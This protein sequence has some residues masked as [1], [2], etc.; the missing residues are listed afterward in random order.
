M[1]Q[2]IQTND[3]SNPTPAGLVALAIA[4]FSSFAFLSVSINASAMPLFGIW[5][6][7]GIVLQFVA[8]LQN[9]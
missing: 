5:L 6:V 4:C 2:P 7:S 1:N 3:W 8:A 9:E